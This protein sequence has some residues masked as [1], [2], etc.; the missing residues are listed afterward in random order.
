LVHDALAHQIDHATLA[1]R[2]DPAPYLTG[3]LGYRPTDEPGRRV[4]DRRATAVEH[5]RHHVLGLPYAT[6]AAP[7]G[8]P[9]S[10]QALG[11]RPDDPQERVMYDRARDPQPTLDIGT[12]L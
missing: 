11:R 8:A 1:L 9:A 12:E 3:L 6:P 2:Q 7:A 5:Y 4:W 10:E